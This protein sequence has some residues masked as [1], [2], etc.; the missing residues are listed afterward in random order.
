MFISCFKH[1]LYYTNENGYKP[2]VLAYTKTTYPRGRCIVLSSKPSNKTVIPTKLLII[3]NKTYQWPNTSDSLKLTVYISDAV[4]SI[5]F[6]P[7][8]FEMQGDRVNFDTEDL[9]KAS[10]G[11]EYKTRTSQLYHVKGDPAL[12]CY[13]YSNQ[14]TYDNCVKKEITERYFLHII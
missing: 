6:N 14:F 1:V 3:M 8:A 11:Y 7:L 10:Y 2:A 13:E 5:Q 4:N 12:E 9:N